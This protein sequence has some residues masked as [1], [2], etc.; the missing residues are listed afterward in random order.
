MMMHAW[1]GYK[2]YSWGG[3]EL[4]PVNNKPRAGALFDAS[5]TTK[6]GPFPCKTAFFSMLIG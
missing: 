4:D 5:G 6:L 3:Q 2:K 1:D